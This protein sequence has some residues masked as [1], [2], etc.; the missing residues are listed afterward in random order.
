MPAAPYIRPSLVKPVFRK[1]PGTR[2]A[3]GLVWAPRPLG[4]ASRRR[5]VPLGMLLEL[6]CIPGVQLYG[7]Q[8]G[9]AARDIE[10]LGAEVLVH[11]LEPR[12]RDWAD[13]AAH[14]AGLDVV[15]SIDSAP[16]HLAGAMGKDCVGLLPYVPCWRWGFERRDS[17]WYPTMQLLRQRAP[18]DWSGPIK[19][20][21]HLL[22]NAV[23]TLECR[24][25]MPD[26]KAGAGVVWSTAR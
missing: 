3:V 19:E 2:L 14:I 15:V 24:H 23:A 17:P 12:L 20:L 5:S 10:R 7:L 18:G 21:R 16:L 26:A 25:P 22:H 6:A 8:V 11:D 9:D 13:T 1:P 4:E